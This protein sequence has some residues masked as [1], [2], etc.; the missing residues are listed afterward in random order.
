MNGTDIHR[1]EIR[2]LPPTKQDAYYQILIAV[3]KI[4]LPQ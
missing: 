2:N 1:E 4:Q 3:K